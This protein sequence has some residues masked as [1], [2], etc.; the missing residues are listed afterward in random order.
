MS[1]SCVF[2]SDD[3]DDGSESLSIMFTDVETSISPV[4]TLFV[5]ELVQVDVHNIR[6]NGTASDG[7]GNVLY[8][9]TR[10]NGDIAAQGEVVLSEDPLKLPKSITA[11]AIYPNYGG[12][13][14]V[15]V[16]LLIG[17]SSTKSSISIQSFRR[18]VSMIPLM[19]IVAVAFFTKK[20]ELS[21]ILGT[22]TGA[23]I[24]TGTVNDGFKTTFNVFLLRAITDT[25][26][27]W[28]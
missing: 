3:N 26:H 28:M 2:G 23:C 17:H 19:V 14:T 5:D 21:F 10:V 22:F 25:S 24:L 8:Y 7:N 6:W 1:L 20:V 15:E 11:G 13:N 27:M 16:E 18:W 9:I 12:S 4:S